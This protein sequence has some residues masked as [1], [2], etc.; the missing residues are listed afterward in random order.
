MNVYWEGKNADSLYKC[1]VIADTN[2]ADT[3]T[4]SHLY[5]VVPITK[6]LSQVGWA[7]YKV[8]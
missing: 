8:R 5:L 2:V 1:T 6:T 3:V 7:D 4:P